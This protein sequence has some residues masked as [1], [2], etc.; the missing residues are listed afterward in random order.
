MGWFLSLYKQDGS[1]H[2]FTLIDGVDL[3]DLQTQLSEA[4]PT[5]VVR[6]PARMNDQMREAPVFVRPDRWDAWR[7]FH[8]DA[9]TIE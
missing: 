9:E 4:G 3:D 6:V 5:S 1:D 7:L 2:V 8:H